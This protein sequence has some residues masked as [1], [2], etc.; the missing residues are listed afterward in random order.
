[1]E[2]CSSGPVESATDPEQRSPG[3]FDSEK[4][5]EHCSSIPFAELNAAE[6]RCSVSVEQVKWS[7]ASLLRAI[8]EW[9]RPGA[10]LL[11]G[12]LRVN[13]RL[14]S[15]DLVDARQERSPA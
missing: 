2:H 8:Y 7:G 5:A 6:H 15:S 9:K 13:F 11:Q 10:L 14:G 3:S 1:M 12:F 4:G